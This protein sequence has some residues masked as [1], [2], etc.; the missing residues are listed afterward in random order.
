MLL[1]GAAA[2]GLVQGLAGFGLGLVAAA[3][4]SG[5]LTPQVAAPLVA[6][7]SLA[8]QMLTIRTVARSIDLRGTAPMLLG[9]LAGVPAG[10]ALLPL[11]DPATFR[12]CV[13]LLLCFY[14]PSMLA[15]RSLPTI[16]WGGGWADAA[17]GVVGGVMGGI[18][19]LSGPAPTI[20]CAVRGWDRDRSRAAFQSFL[21]VAQAAG[22][23]GYAFSGL[24]T[25]DVWRLAAW[26]LP[27]VLLSS[28][29]GIRLYARLGGEAFRRL[30][31][32]LLLATGA[33]LVVEG[34]A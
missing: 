3:F 10:V 14:C 22:L 16:R 1:F 23:A 9:G 18:A 29:L 26:M 19:G 15:L 31:L 30:I 7:C 20:W 17:A 34:L 25:R 21:I 28:L 8:G 12:L 13:G 24:L 33:V 5:A 6:I 11:I 32:I 27:F 2:A 4:W